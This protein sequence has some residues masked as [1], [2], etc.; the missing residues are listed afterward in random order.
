MSICNFLWG[1]T[2]HPKEHSSDVKSPLPPLARLHTAT[3]PQDRCPSGDQTAQLV[4]KEE[5]QK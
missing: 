2:A 3:L 4:E 5:R 1:H